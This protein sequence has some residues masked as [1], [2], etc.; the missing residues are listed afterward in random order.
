MFYGNYTYLNA[1]SL[2]AAYIIDFEERCVVELDSNAPSP[3][4][5]GGLNIST[6]WNVIGKTC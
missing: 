5:I 2:T 4:L 6:S 3:K 1:H